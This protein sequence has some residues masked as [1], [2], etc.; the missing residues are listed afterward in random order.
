MTC[1]PPSAYQP[2][3]LTIKEALREAR[4]TLYSSES[5]DLDAQ[6]L[7]AQL[8]SVERVYLLA[9]GEDALG[10]TQIWDYQALLHRRAAGEPIAYITGS[11][12][13]YDL[14]LIVTPAVLIPRPET[15]HLLEEALRLMA[16]RPDCQAADIGSGSGALAVAFARHQP[17]SRV[18]AT[19]ISANA[20]RVARKNAG[21]YDASIEF[22]LGDLASPI[23]ERGIKLDLLMANLPY[24]PS[25]YLQSLAVIKYEPVLALDGG[26][27][28]LRYFRRLLAQ[29]PQV[30]HAGAW[31]LL[32]IGADQADAVRALVEELVAVSSDVLKDYAGLNRIIRF[33]LNPAG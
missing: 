12:W 23:L 26:D 33:Q 5:A 14:E 9:H 25:D 29:V 24:M 17:G 31:V 19:D 21:R 6:L 16:Q 22:M 11:K 32:E 18:C 28:G 4:Q 30:C 20:L 7:L 1:V 27:D 2:D 15:E 3:M 13:F 10:E 8:L